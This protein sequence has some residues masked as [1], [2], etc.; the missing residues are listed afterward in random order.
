[1]MIGKLVFTL[2]CLCNDFSLTPPL[3][4]ITLWAFSH[5]FHRL[6]CSH[7]WVSNG[8][9][10]CVLYAHKALGA[11]VKVTSLKHWK[12]EFI[13]TQALVDISFFSTIQAQKS[14]ASGSKTPAQCLDAAKVVWSPPLTKHHTLNLYLLLLMNNRTGVTAL[15]CCARYI[16]Y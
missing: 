13:L 10:C 6:I 2:I 8:I 5:H 9:K 7:V 1:M 3:L 15:H 16:K 12:N 4:K 14:Q 11:K